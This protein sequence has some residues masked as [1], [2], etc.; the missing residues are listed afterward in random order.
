M[1]TDRAML[2]GRMASVKANAII[3]KI[4]RGGRERVPIKHG[5][6][7]TKL[8][9]VWNGMKQRCVN[10]KHNAYK[11]YGGRG[12]TVC[13]EWQEFLPFYKWCMDNGYKEGLT[14]DR[15]D[16]SKGYMPSNC[17]FVDRYIQANNNRRN[18][19]ITANGETKT[20]PEWSRQLG[21]KQ[22][23]LYRRYVIKKWSG[24]KTI[25]TPLLKKGDKKL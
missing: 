10:P 23:T 17:R 12:I 20:L 15:V 4:G 1:T 19:L 8:H 5:L 7:H 2:A 24:D 21:F 16:N 25:N 11:N 14:L 18:I 6:Y 13:E 9:G 22:G 3:S